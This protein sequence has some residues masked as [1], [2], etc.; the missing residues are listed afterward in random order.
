MG[1]AIDEHDDEGRRKVRCMECSSP[2]KFFHRLD[3]HLGSKHHMNVLEYLQI[4][5]G[6]RVLSEAAEAEGGAGAAAVKKLVERAHAGEETPDVLKIGVA[7]LPVR[8]GLA[9]E[10]LLWVP[11]HD[12]DWDSETAGASTLEALAVAMQDDDNVLIVGPPGVGK[13]SVARELA[14]MS[15][16]PLRRMNFNGDLRVSDFLGSK[17]LVVD[18]KSGQSVTEFSLGPM[19][20]SSKRGHWMLWDEFDSCPPPVGFVM[21][22]FLETPRHLTVPGYGDVVVDP[23]TRVIAVA[24]TLGYGDDTGLYSGTGPVNEAL[25]DRFQVVIRMN[26]PEAGAEAAMLVKRFGV[27]AEIAAK[28]VDVATKVREA[29]VAQNTTV[30]MSTRRL[31]AWGKKIARFGEKRAR[32]AAQLTVLNKLPETDLKF[33]DG[34]IQRIIGG[35]AS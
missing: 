21:H 17:Q 23:E 6:A 10:D 13:S 11:D 31:V 8:K 30:S 9:D 32:F 24:N 35:S 2:P 15:K 34:L 33:V 5:P 1:S 12:E 22:P 7:R 18:G 27:S 4:H 16:N 28:M 19:P 14:W 20:Y 25:L 26:Y 3:V 29:Q